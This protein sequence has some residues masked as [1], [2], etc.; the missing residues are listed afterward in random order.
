MAWSPDGKRLA[1]ASQDRTTNVWETT[2]GHELLTLKG[3]TDSVLSV[4]WSPDGKRLATASLDHTVKVW[5]AVSGQES[6]TLNGFT[7]S[8]WSMAWSQDGK[9]L[10]T[11]GWDGTVKVYAIDIHDLLNLARSRVTRD[12]TSEECQRYFQAKIC[13][14]RP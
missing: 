13:P 10:A 7:D 6:L 2:S 9:R 11:V 1:T 8:V 14:A 4:A 5:D 12:L 3:H